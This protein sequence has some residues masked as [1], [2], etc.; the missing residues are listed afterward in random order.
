[1]SRTALIAGASG[2]V[3][4]HCLRLLLAEPAYDRVVALG[5]RRVALTHAKLHQQIVD[6]ARLA[7]I[8]EPPRIDDAF[9]CLGTTMRRAGSRGAFR[10][11]DLTYVHELARFAVRGGAMRFLLVSSM[12]AD[13]GARNFYTRVKGEAE[14][15][16]RATV[17]PGALLF[18]PSL[19]MGRRA[20]VRMGER[21]G[22]ALS[23]ALGFLFV[24]PLRRYRPIAAETVARAMLRV[25]LEGHGGPRVYRS[26]EI[27]ALGASR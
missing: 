24:G 5:R 25:A 6:F 9:C 8:A 16:V 22:I 3:G 19:L 27:A 2:L 18:R 26:D 15:A 11:V 7:D 12:G 23:R 1:M 13:P 4:S 20:E 17:G 14:A 10:R 21:A